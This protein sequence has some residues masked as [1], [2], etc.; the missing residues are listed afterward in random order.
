MS[1]PRTLTFFGG[2]ATATGSMILLEAAGA[3][4]LLDAGRF[5]GNLAQAEA[6]NRD[7]PLN[8]EKVDAILLSQAG[9]AYAGRAPQLVRHGYTGP[10]FSTLGT[11]DVAAILLPEAALELEKLS[12][13]SALYDLSDALSTLSRFVGEPYRLSLIHI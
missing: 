11:H 8:P 13:K 2:A 9:L 1:A 6:W 7:L 3:Q 12:A 5:R 4:V 10:I